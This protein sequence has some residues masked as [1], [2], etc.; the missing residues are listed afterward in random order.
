MKIRTLF[1]NIRTILI[2]PKHY[3]SNI[4]VDGKMDEAMWKAFL[5]GLVG[6]LFVLCILVFIGDSLNISNIFK[7]MIITPILSVLLLYLLGGILMFVAEITGG[8]PD[9]EIAIKGLVSIF[10]LYPLIL[11]LNV[12]A[13]TCSALWIISII[14]DLYI[15]F[16]FY[17]LSL[18]C[19]RGKKHQVV[20]VTLLL[21]VVFISIYI[22]DYR[23]TWFF[24]K[25]TYGALT[26]L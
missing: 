22:T 1:Q 8:D 12:F 23:L 10:F 17:N 19:M 25:N 18:Y 24:I 14:S 15:V 4:I 2:K 5:Y 21:I 16:L 13:N 20:L 6:G 3:F 9:W 26:C 7:T 11:V